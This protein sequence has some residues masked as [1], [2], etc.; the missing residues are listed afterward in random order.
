MNVG[1]L[2]RLIARRWT[3]VA[4]FTFGGLALVW[5]IA[6]RFPTFELK[7]A[8]YCSEATVMMDTGMQGAAGSAA[9]PRIIART[10]NDVQ[11]VQSATVAERASHRLKGRYT[12]EEIRSTTGAEAKMATQVMVISACG[13]SPSDAPLVTDAVVQGY[14]EWID[15]RQDAAN[16]LGPN[17]IEVTVLSPPLEPTAPSGFPPIVWIVIGLIGGLIVGVIVSVGVE[18]VQSSSALASFDADAAV[19]ANN[20]SQASSPATSAT[21]NFS[22]LGRHGASVPHLPAVTT[23][24]ARRR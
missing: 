12:T 16:V 22:P 8:S 21:P 13:D 6:F 18:G 24:R 5:L 23:G 2:I 19:P 1:D 3:I 4:G 9:L 17:R 10:I 14:R 7:S 15:E 11:V 20:G